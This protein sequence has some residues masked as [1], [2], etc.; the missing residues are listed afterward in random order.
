MARN[1]RDNME[2]AREREAAQDASYKNLYGRHL[3]DVE[4]L[5]RKGFVITKSAAG[6]EVDNKTIDSETLRALA[7]RERR[8]EGNVTSES[9]APQT[10]DETTETCPCGKPIRHMGNC[11]HRRGLSGPPVK[12]AAVRA[13]ARKPARA[14]RAP[15]RKAAAVAAARSGVDKL[16]A[17]IQELTAEIERLQGVLEGVKSAK[18][19]WIS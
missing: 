7:D 13:K 11:W 16:D 19:A 1:A 14:K 10:T 3:A 2:I 15:A 9:D 5:R 6:F 8:L 17:L 4:F 12:K 18:A